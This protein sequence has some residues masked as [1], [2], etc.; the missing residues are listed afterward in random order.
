MQKD[1]IKVPAQQACLHLVSANLLSCST[2]L[3]CCY[4]ILL[5]HYSNLLCH[6][7]IPLSQ[8]A[9]LLIP[10]CSTAVRTL[11]RAGPHSDT[12]AEDGPL[13]GE[14]SSSDTASPGGQNR[15]A[16]PGGQGPAGSGSEGMRSQ[17]SPAEAHGSVLSLPADR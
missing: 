9:M 10:V 2:N 14:D 13:R 7:S 8:F 1:S 12:E 17:P 6:R 16:V 15:R 3:L 5:Y 4:P 11:S